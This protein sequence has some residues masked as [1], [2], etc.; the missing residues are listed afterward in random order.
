MLQP[1]VG[2]MGGAQ[3]TPIAAQ[4]AYDLGQHIA[5]AGWILLTGGRAVGV[6]DAASQGAK[7][8]GG[9]TIGILPGTDYGGVSAA[10]DIAIVTGMGDARNVINVLSSQVIIACGGGA[11][12]LSEIALALK[13]G[14]PVI[15]LQPSETEQ[16][17]T[18]RH[19]VQ[20]LSPTLVHVV[21]TVP[22]AIDRVRMCLIPESG[23][24]PSPL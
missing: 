19:L 17:R 14:K 9:L 23:R 16:A 22:Q 8:A 24:S 7:A 20:E 15:L 21:D 18:L 6:M 1:I 4:L 5:Q 12:T 11:G 3:T 13:A 10:V 2:V